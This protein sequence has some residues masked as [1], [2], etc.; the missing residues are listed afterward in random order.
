MPNRGVGDATLDEHG[1]LETQQACDVQG[2][3]AGDIAE[4]G[5]LGRV[6]H[7]HS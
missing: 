4:T 3:G 5:V 2:H 1:A 7:L 6:D